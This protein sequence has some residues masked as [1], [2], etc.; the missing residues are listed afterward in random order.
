M[1]RMVGS[2]G[3]GRGGGRG[4]GGGERPEVG[5]VGQHGSSVSLCQDSQR[6]AD[7][8]QIG[9]EVVSFDEL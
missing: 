2:N 5:Q 9:G 6:Q 3:G 1:R 7:E 4:G 8:F